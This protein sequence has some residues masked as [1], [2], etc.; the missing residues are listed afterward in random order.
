ME[1]EQDIRGTLTKN[2]LPPLLRKI[3]VERRTGTLSLSRPEETHHF[4]FEMGELRTVTS[5]KE[6]QRI[7]AFL[8]RRGVINDGQ[9]EEALASV[10]GQHR[11]R[12]G[13]LLLERGYVTKP[14]LDSEM[15][16][17][18]EE[19][20]FST[21]TWDRAEYAFRASAGRLDPDVAV[22]LSTAAVVVEGIRRLPESEEF[23]ELLG[24]L[25]RAAAV[26]ADPT[27][28]YQFIALAPQEALLLSR[29]DRTTRLR[30]LLKMGRS[31]LESAKALYALLACGLIEP[32][33][34]SADSRAQP[35]TLL[36]A[37]NVAPANAGA[38][39][40]TEAAELE[41]HRKLI[42]E[43]YRRIDW[44]SLYELLGATEHANGAEL[45]ERYHER[46]R[47]FHP[48]LKF[49]EGLRD[50]EKELGCLY[51]RVQKAYALLSNSEERAKYDRE[52][53]ET[54]SQEPWASAV[55]DDEARSGVA[56][57]NYLE[58]RKLIEIQDYYGAIL[59]LQ[60]AIRLSP[61]NAEYHFR[62]AGALAKNQHWLERAQL[63]YEEA[64]RLDPYRKEAQ[65]EYCEFLVTSGHREDAHAV[66]E[67]LVE[68]WPE[69]RH[70]QQVL[71]RTSPEQ[72]R[73]ADGRSPRRTAGTA[74]GDEVPT[75]SRSIFSRL[76]RRG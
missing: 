40:P 55:A 29:C 36:E 10:A 25:D 22:D 64:V 75:A 62:L 73:G 52:R 76:F 74:E 70:L 38:E 72:A 43:T 14:V 9:L 23:V 60:E 27:S 59:L 7:G 51:D 49:R 13:R 61:E 53:L 24:D 30:D 44:I 45:D 54:T 34:P 47:L 56:R 1:A 5:S 6:E 50:L 31:R 32:V 39:R 26:S 21:F 16:R 68:R 35:P 2:A 4:F 19:I 17:L 8:K 41:A 3:F 67:L 46:S 12:L 71:A 11:S 66:A 65:Q 58:A 48:D 42:R 57:A 69:D 33:S 18:V 63:Q 37:L 28:R 20:V 15:H